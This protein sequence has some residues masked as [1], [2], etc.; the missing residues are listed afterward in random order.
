MIESILCN[1]V[2]ILVGFNKL[3]IPFSYLSVY[4]IL[5]T[6]FCFYKL[7]MGKPEKDD[8]IITSIIDKIL[9]ISIF[10][11]QFLGFFNFPHLF[12]LVIGLKLLIRVA[13]KL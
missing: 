3:T 8:T 10:S 11:I 12:L 7:L 13:L 9:Y 5:S 6:G 1:I 4:V 2:I